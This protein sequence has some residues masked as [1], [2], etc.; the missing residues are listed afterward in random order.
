MS[1]LKWPKTCKRSVK[2]YFKTELLTV[3]FDCFAVSRFF[4]TTEWLDIDDI[5]TDPGAYGVYP[6][7][8]PMQS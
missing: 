5:M 2:R 6:K 1:E 3:S 8:V 7:Y 4:Q